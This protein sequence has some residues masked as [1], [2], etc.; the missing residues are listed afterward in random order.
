MRSVTGAPALR[1]DWA[2]AALP[3]GRAASPL[4]LG[5]AQP[6]WIA[7]PGPMTAAAA[8]RT[9]GKWSASSARDFDA[10]DWWF[11]CR[12]T[13]PSDAAA[14][15]RFDGLA[16]VADAWLNDTHL[17]HSEN[18]FLPQEAAAAGLRPGTNELLLRFHALTPLL[19]PRRPRPRWKTR[20][21]TH[22]SLRWFRTT[23]LGRIPEWCPAIA[24]VGPWRAVRL[25]QDTEVAGA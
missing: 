12:F 6:E 4:E 15:L 24:P 10:E 5:A 17:L 11:R 22:Q 3:P 14:I 9:A 19:A 8:L 21:V 20:L 23:L 1:G 25:L 2:L 7:C 16:T 18:M 13:P